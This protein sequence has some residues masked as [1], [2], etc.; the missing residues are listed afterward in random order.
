M[1]SKCLEMLNM[2]PA[3][4]L[5]LLLATVGVLGA[6]ARGDGKFFVKVGP[7]AEADD[8]RVIYEGLAAP[9]ILKFDS[10]QPI[11]PLI[12]TATVG[13]ETEILIYTLS[14][15]KLTCKERLALRH[16]G[17]TSPELLL[18]GLLAQA[19]IEEWPLLRDVPQRA[20]MLCKFKGRLTPTQMSQDLEFT[21]A[22]DNQPY[23][24]RKIV[25]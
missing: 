23:R 2:R 15:A 7:D 5:L 21:P 20:M 9:L 4:R 18:R 25:W 10:E 6:D 13:T 1:I 19:E 8:R 16:A 3:V 24:E 11:Y 17:R 12:L 22:Q 14:D